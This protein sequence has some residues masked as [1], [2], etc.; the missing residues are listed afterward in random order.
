MS[1]LL[2]AVH[3][4]GRDLTAATIVAANVN[5]KSHRMRA[6]SPSRCRWPGV[7]RARRAGWRGRGRSWPSFLTHG[8]LAHGRIIR[9]VLFEKL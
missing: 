6:P 1:R 9:E 2:S 8:T 3:P 5:V 4:S 7:D